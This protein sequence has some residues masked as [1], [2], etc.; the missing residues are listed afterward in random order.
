MRYA[1]GMSDVTR[2][3]NQIVQGNSES[4]EQLLPLVYTELRRLASQKMVHERK[5]HTLS[6]TALV[7]EAFVRLVDQET[8]QQWD[9]ARH[10]FA[11]AAEAMR[12]ILIERARQKAT[13]KHGGAVQKFEL[14]AVD[15]V[16]LPMVC[17]DILGLEEAIQKLEQEHPRKAELVK[18]RF[19]AG[20]T[21]AQA[22]KVLGVSTSTAENDWTYAKSWLRIEMSRD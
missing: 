20:L 1:R 5:D 3:L 2:I 13:V 21:M 19:F 14:S 22:A 4:T 18:L 17:E 8:Q 10:F 7:H 11:A 12:R 15:P 6:A 16:V 9:S